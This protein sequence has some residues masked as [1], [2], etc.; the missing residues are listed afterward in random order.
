MIT[1]LYVLHVGLVVKYP[2]KYHISASYRSFKHF[3]EDLF[4][5][6]LTSD[7]ETFHPHSLNVDN[8]FV[9]WFSLILKHFNTHAAIQ[10]KRVKT[11]R[12]PYW[13]TPD[14]AEM[15]NR[16]DTSKRLKRWDDYRKL[17]NKTR[18]LI[19]QAK[20]KYFSESVN[21]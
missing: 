13:F 4:L 9:L 2:Q 20:R 18:Q 7:L 15:Q 19:K 14:I 17:R 5:Q 1:D 11:K 10:T 21:N 6:E 3:G 12:L 16:R 8:D